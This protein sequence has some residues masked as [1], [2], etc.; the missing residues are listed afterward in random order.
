ML[1]PNFVCLCSFFYTHRKIKVFVTFAPCKLLIQCTFKQ[2]SN[3]LHYKNKTLLMNELL[4]HRIS[5][6]LKRVEANRRDTWWQR[7]VA[8]CSCLLL[9]IK[10]RFILLLLTFFLLIH[11]LVLLHIVVV[12]ADF[13]STVMSSRGESSHFLDSFFL[14]CHQEIS[15][16]CL[17][18]FVNWI[19][20]KC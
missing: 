17:F 1:C 13:I 11:N 15:Q 6:V 7:Q 8:T 12:C 19:D 4:F 5:F 14:F 16:N 9:A 2:I 18:W 10:E 3:N 20:W